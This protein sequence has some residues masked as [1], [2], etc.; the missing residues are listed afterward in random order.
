MLTCTV[1]SG[2]HAGLANLLT[3]ID[4]TLSQ[5]LYSGWYRHQKVQTL[6]S[7]LQSWL[8]MH[9]KIQLPMAVACWSLR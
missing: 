7:F 6:I 2:H 9:S 4:F 5:S 3:H 1:K 8:G